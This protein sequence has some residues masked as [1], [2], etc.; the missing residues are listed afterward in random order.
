MHDRVRGIQAVGIIFDS[1]SRHLGMFIACGV[2]DLEL[3]ISG[4]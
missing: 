4:C 2:E 1:V 3:V